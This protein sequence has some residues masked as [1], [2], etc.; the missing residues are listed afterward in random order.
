MPRHVLVAKD[1]THVDVGSQEV[2]V[3]ELIEIALSLRPAPTEPPP[4]VER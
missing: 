3:D 4:A 2:P 1:G